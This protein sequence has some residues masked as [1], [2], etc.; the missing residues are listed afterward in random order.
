[1]AYFYGIKFS[2]PED[3]LI[4]A[5]RKVSQWC[6]KNLQSVSDVFNLIAIA[7]IPH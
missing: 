7:N 1:M 5:I 6:L 4:R 3:N 2:A